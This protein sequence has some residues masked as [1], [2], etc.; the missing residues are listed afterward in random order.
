MSNPSQPAPGQPQPGQ[1][2]QHWTQ[3]AQQQPGGQ[4]QGQPQPG[5][6]PWPQQP[7]QFIPGQPPQPP[8]K[9]HTGCKIAGAVIGAMIL[10]GGVSEAIQAGGDGSTAAVTGTT[11]MQSSAPSS[12]PTNTTSKPKHHAAA[13]QSKPHKVLLVKESGNGIKNT[14]SF[15]APDEWRIRY[16][17]DCSSFGY[18]GNFQ[19]FVYDGSDPQDIVVNELGRSG[20]DT[21]PIYQGG[22]HLHLEINSECEW[23]VTALA[24]Q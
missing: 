13:P 23:K 17:Y 24:T 21:T 4:W 19:V 14:A 20:K 6:A 9:K 7:G 11:S 16:S 22:D 5:A 3:P 15:A 2:P 8:K 12:V 10:I 1:Y 18:K